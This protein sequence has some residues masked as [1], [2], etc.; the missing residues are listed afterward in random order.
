MIFFRTII[1]TPK[2][3]IKAVKGSSLSTLK[4]YIPYRYDVIARSDLE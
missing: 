2:N 3:I 4:Q 1:I